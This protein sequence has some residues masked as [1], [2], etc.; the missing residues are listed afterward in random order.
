MIQEYSLG[1]AA[2][3][4]KSDL[5]GEFPVYIYVSED[6]RKL[7]YSKSITNL[8]HDGRVKKPLSIANQGCSFLLRNGF[9]PPPKTI[10]KNIFII[11]IG[12]IAEIR[13]KKGEI[14]INFRYDFPFRNSNRLHH[15]EMQPD[16]DLILQLVAEA[17]ISRIDASKPSFLFHSAG[18]DSNTIALALAE[19]GWQDRVTLVTHKSKGKADESEISR[20]IAN[21][22]GFKHH[23]LYE[24][25]SLEPQHQTHIEH[26]FERMPFPSVDNVTLAYPLYA[27][28]FPDLI[29]ANIIDGGG[30]DTYMGTPLT[31]RDKQKLL[32]SQATLPLSF[33]LWF[34]DSPHVLQRLLCEPSEMFAGI[35]FSYKDIKAIYPEMLSI[36]TCWESELFLG[37]NR[38]IF[39]FKTGI[40]T[41]AS[42]A[43]IR[44]VRIFTDVFD[45]RLILPFASEAVAGY[46]R[47]L[48]EHHLFSRRDLKNKLILREIL[49]NRLNLDSDAI[50]KMGFSYD[51]VNLVDL[52]WIAITREIRECSLWDTAQTEKILRR[53]RRIMLAKK[54]YSR[55]SARLI[56][57]LYLLSAWL[58]Y[59]QYIKS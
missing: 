15:D 5:A 29:G 28:Q 6:K 51:S 2:L 35:N 30:N 41:L 25:D 7:L 10:Y 20:S 49:K 57:K 1:D 8:L 52:N 58:N 18:K 21:K 23:I 37:Y 39:G 22:L 24:V 9:V 26:F 19:A 53:L 44:K 27:L 45:A 17:T 56:Y 3:T 33:L 13:T 31:K 11:S 36:R 59:S 34:F 54:K 50:G 32:L 43:Y 55:L 4:L 46:F 48:P 14:S 47:K 40:R 42:E 12:N 16:E 38:D